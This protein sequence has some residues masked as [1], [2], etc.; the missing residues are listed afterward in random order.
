MET[1]IGVII[2]GT[3]DATVDDQ[4]GQV[5]S[6]IEYRKEQQMDRLLERLKA[7]RPNWK[8]CHIDKRRANGRRLFYEHAL[9]R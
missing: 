1:S 8:A 9:S 6:A 5:S 2:F 3:Y 7:T 4:S